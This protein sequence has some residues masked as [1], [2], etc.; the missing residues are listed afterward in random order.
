MCMPF[1]TISNKYQPLGK[2]LTGNP[3]PFSNIR[4]RYGR[5]SILLI[6]AQECQFRTKGFVDTV[7]FL[8]LAQPLLSLSPIC[9]VAPTVICTVLGPQH[10]SNVP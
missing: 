5:W 10:W 9:F 1:G 6:G 4:P 3:P 7:R 2:I 8:C